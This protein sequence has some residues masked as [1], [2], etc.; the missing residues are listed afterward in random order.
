[1][2]K[3]LLQSEIAE[4]FSEIKVVELDEVPDGSE[5]QKSLLSLSGRNTV[6]NIFIQGQVYMYIFLL[7]CTCSVG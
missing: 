7:C 4:R 1:M 3:E 6:P 2:A 5:L